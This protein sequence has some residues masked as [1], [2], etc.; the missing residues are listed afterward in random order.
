MAVKSERMQNTN[1]NK[2]WINKYL[3]VSLKTDGFKNINNNEDVRVNVT[4]RSI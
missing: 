2:T 1:L 4:V 3:M